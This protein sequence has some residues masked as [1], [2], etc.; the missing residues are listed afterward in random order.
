M[1]DLSSLDADQRGCDSGSPPDAVLQAFSAKGTPTRLE[2]GQ[3]QSYRAGEIV[4]KPAVDD[5]ETNWIAGFYLS[6]ANDGFRLPA[7]VRG[8]NG[9]FVVGGWQAWRYADGEHVEGGWD[10]KVDLCVRFHRAIAG[11][12]RPDYFDRRDR[13][14]WVVADRVTW[15]EL[16]IEH[17]PR[18]APIV[19]RLRSCLRPV[20][21]PNQLIHGDFGGNVLFDDGLAPAIIDLS[22]YWRPAAFALGVLIADAIVWEGADVS[23]IEAGTVYDNFVQHLARAELRRIIEIDTIY[24]MYGWEMLDEIEAHLPLI[25]HICDLC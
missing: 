4:L 2:G 3:G 1:S 8:G 23:L 15:D 25:G 13:N 12:P 22:P 7:P 18:I 11:V 9:R 20:A 6:V 24:R 17:H 10:E 19:D 14:P 16:A 5:A 21:A